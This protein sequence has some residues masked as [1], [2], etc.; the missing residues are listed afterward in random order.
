M[1]QDCSSMIMTWCVI[2]CISKV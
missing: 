2:S 1:L